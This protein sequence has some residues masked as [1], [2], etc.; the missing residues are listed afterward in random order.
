MVTPAPSSTSAAATARA[1]PT[2]DTRSPAQRFE[3]TFDVRVRPDGAPIPNHDRVDRADVG[4]DRRDLVKVRHDR[5]LERRRDA[6]AAQVDGLG[7]PPEV[8]LVC[9]L[10]R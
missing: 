8:R 4:G 1:A 9:R 10:E 5:D 6:R 3:E 2:A 7:E